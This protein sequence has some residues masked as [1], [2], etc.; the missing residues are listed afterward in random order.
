MAILSF[1]FFNV[2]TF[3]EKNSIFLIFFQK[4]IVFFRKVV[5]NTYVEVLL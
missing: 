4:N 1:T 5:Y 2:N 3:F